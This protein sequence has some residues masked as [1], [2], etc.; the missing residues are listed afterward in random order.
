M[1]LAL[2]DPHH[3]LCIKVLLGG[4]VVRRPMDFPAISVYA[5]R[6]GWMLAL[7]NDSAGVSGVQSM[8]DVALPMWAKAY[9]FTSPH[10]RLSCADDG[11]KDNNIV[12][13]LA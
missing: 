4:R 12:R 13:N 8:S 2:P 3:N 10:G 7:V 9:A 11:K 5:E 6:R 1:L